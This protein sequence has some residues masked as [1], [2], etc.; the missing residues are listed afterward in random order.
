MEMTP[1]RRV[2]LGRTDTDRCSPRTEPGAAA[3]RWPIGGDAVLTEKT[4]I[5]LEAVA[6]PDSWSGP[7]FSEADELAVLVSVADHGLQVG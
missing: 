7:C 6:A 4:T 1:A 2:V 5:R 3:S